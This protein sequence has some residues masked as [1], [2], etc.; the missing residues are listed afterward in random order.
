MLK[1]KFAH[2]PMCF[3]L[4]TSFC[5]NYHILLDCCLKYSGMVLVVKTVNVISVVIPAVIRQR[6]CYHK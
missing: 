3:L 1:N 6:A 5:I 2:G 4:Q